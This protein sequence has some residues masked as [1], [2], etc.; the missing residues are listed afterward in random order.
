VWDW[1]SDSALMTKDYHFYD[2][3]NMENNCTAVDRLQW[4]YNAGTFLPGA[5]YMYNYTNG[6]SKWLAVVEGILNGT[7]TFYNS[8]NV[9]Y[10][11][12]CEMQGKC[13]TDERCFKAILSKGLAVTAQLVPSLKPLILAKLD[14]SAQ[15]AAKQ[16]SGGT[17]GVTCG[18]KWMNPTWDG[19]YGVGE[20]LSA[21]AVIQSNLI[22]V[23]DVS[24][25]V[26]NST[27]GTSKG[28]PNAGN[29]DGSGTGSPTAKK[30]VT[31][32][33]RAGAAI[34]TALVLLAVLGASWWMVV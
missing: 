13:D 29:G 24:P 15:G 33:D 7:D 26:T 22:F 17:D 34:L 32:G 28:N 5:A 23:G 11:Y 30:P 21:L 16:C 18:E 12:T 14:T 2:G 25:P 27:G 3:T 4:S 20:Q 10:E 6:D 1:Y 19:L 9:M 31:T 8:G